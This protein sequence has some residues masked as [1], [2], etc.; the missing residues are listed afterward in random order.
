MIHFQSVV[1]FGTLMFF[2]LS[3]GTKLYYFM[4]TPSNMYQNNKTLP[5]GWS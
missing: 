4:G 3:K 5:K 1:R 2:T